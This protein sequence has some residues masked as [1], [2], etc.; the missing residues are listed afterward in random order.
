M[1]LLEIYLRTQCYWPFYVILLLLGIRLVGSSSPRKGLVQVY[2]NKTWG[3]V[4][5]DQWD[6]IDADVACR[7]MSFNGALSVGFV[8]QSNKK[9][10]LSVWIRNVQCFKNESSLLACSH[11]KRQDCANDNIAWTMCRERQGELWN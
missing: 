5:G 4:C 6:K 3:W 8:T 10:N 11:E 7:M 1:L 9:T 2:Y